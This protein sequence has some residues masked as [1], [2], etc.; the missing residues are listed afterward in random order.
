ML[1]GAYNI[2][3]PAILQSLLMVWRH[4]GNSPSE[5]VQFDMKLKKIGKFAIR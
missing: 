1:P 5:P 3:S 4:F 2:P